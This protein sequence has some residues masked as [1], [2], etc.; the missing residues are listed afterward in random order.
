MTT[1]TA[2]LADLERLRAMAAY[3][4]FHPELIAELEEICRESA[5]R[6]DMPLS[7]VQAVLDTA[8]ATMATNAGEADFLSVIGGSPNELSFCPHV[9]LDEAPYVREDLAEDDEHR[10]N[11]AVRAGLV[12]SYAGAPLV[13]PDGHIVGSH[14]VMAPGRHAFSDADIAEITAAAGRAAEAISRFPQPVS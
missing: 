4:L 8:T 6:L 14:C 11:P 12:R 5:E 1:D 9:V 2:K 3:D 13:L 7:A 10:F